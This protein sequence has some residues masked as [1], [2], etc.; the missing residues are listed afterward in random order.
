[1]AGLTTFV[2]YSSVPWDFPEDFVRLW[3]EASMGFLSQKWSLIPTEIARKHILQSQMHK[4]KF[5]PLFSDTE[6]QN[7]AIERAARQRQPNRC[8]RSGQ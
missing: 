2:Q 5:H 8:C 7:I 1:M 6:S 4:Y 3:W